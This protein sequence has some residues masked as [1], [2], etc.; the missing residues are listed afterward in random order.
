MGC[1]IQQN[2]LRVSAQVFATI[3]QGDALV[4][5][6][7]T[8]FDLAANVA[9]LPLDFLLASLFEASL[10]CQFLTHFFAHGFVEN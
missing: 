8:L 7:F 9:P 3:R 6:R 2:K 5:R 4:L 1:G 10:F